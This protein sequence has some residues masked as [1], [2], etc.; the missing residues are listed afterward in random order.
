MYGR[1]RREKTYYRYEC[2][3]TG[4]TYRL[5]RESKNPSDLVSVEGYYQMHPE[6]DDRPAVV[7]KKLGVTTTTST[8]SSK[9]NS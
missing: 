4:K 8:D 3:L 1:R 9:L 7:K 5:T 2:T 6:L